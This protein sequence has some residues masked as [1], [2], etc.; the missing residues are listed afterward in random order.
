[1]AQSI[2]ATKG[3]W[4]TFFHEANIPED[5]AKQYSEIFYT[6]RM[7]FNALHELTKEDLSDLGII[8]LGDIKNILRKAKASS[9]SSQNQTGSS[10]IFIKAPAAKLPQLNEDMTLPQFRKFKMDWDVFKRITNLPESQIH[11]QLYNACSESVQNSLVSTKSDFFSLTEEKMMETLEKIVTKQCNPPV[12]WLHFRSVHQLQEESI[13]DFVVRLR[14][15]APNCEFQ[16]PNCH[17]DLQSIN[18]KD[19]FIRGL[20]NESI[21]TDIIAKAS[22]LK[23][24]EDVI[25]H[26][27]AFETAQCDQIQLQGSSEVMAAHMSAYQK[28]KKE[29]NLPKPQITHP[30]SGCGSYL[31]GQLGSNDRSTKCPAWE[32]NCL[33]CKIPNHFAR[34]CQQQSQS[35]SAQ[36]LIASVEYDQDSDTFTTTFTSI[37]EIPAILSPSLPRQWHTNPVKMNIFQGNGASICLAGPQHIAK[38]NLDTHDL[39]P[40]YKQVKAVGG[41]KLTCHGWLPITFQIG[42]NTT[43]KSRKSQ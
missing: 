13:K 34:V 12:H 20:H 11:A 43:R 38:F 19:Q 5:E 33:N 26:S 32:K 15:S 29:P 40:C 30:C 6:N 39:I 18:I 35:D 23:T 1:M 14:S 7:T 28:K 3:Q 41:S 16:C 27:E 25:K 22:Q 9:A 4:E 10:N 37:E 31:H 24:L 17:F 8:V 42:K 2:A 21:Q 36:A